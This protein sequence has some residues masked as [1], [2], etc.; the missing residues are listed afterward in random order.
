MVKNTLITC[1]S[2][3]SSSAIVVHDS[4]NS[5]VG[6][7]DWHSVITKMM[8]N[9]ENDAAANRLMMTEIIKRCQVYASP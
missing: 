9:L 6:S 5:E 7:E 8:K 4:V 2:K 3:D 1:P